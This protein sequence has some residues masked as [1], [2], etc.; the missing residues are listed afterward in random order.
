[1]KINTIFFTYRMG[2]GNHLSVGGII[3]QYGHLE[4]QFG[5]VCQNSTQQCTPPSPYMTVLL[6][7]NHQRLGKKGKPLL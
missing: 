2:W 6:Y 1:M 3:N 7:K 5:S 4:R